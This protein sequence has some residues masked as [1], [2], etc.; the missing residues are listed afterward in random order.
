MSKLIPVKTT[1]I[2]ADL[3]ARLKEA[4]LQE[5]AKEKV[6]SNKYISIKGGKFSLGEDDL[7]ENLKVVIIGSA[8]D[9]A[10]YSGKYDPK[11]TE[12]P[13]CFAVAEN[14]SDLIPNDGNVY[15]AQHSDCGSCPN[16]QWKSADNGTGKACK[17]SRRLLVIPVDPETLEV[18][19]DFE[20]MLIRL[21]P[22]SLSSYAKYVKLVTKKHEVPVFGIIT[23]LGFDDNVEYPSVKFHDIEPIQDENILEGI[24]NLREAE[25]STL[26]GPYKRYE[27]D[28][29]PVKK[30]KRG[31]F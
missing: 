27:P 7:G 30:N 5:V 19:V 9:N 29:A 28:T 10:F 20:P 17:N 3:K 4:A 11:H 12:S 15:E 1:P 22:T 21:P 31:K 18:D 14:E 16:N 25:I 13:I 8:Y 23:E 2:S 24:L 26:L 6:T